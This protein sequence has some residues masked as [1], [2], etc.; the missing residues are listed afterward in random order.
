MGT[1]FSNKKL[2]LLIF[3]LFLGIFAVLTFKIFSG[4]SRLYSCQDVLDKKDGIYTIYP[5]GK[6]PVQARCRFEKG[7]AWTLIDISLDKNWISYF[8][9]PKFDV[10]QKGYLL[11]SSCYSY[12]DWFRVSS[13]K[14]NFATSPDC[15]NIVEE[16]KVYRATGNFYGCLW[17]S[18]NDPKNSYY[19]GPYDF[20]RTASSTNKY[21]DESGK[22]WSC[23]NDW[24]NTAPSIGADGK[25]CVAYTN[26]SFP[27]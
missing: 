14:M 2:F 24:W 19:N 26:F 16:N 1:D 18:G 27:D 3:L 10:E 4:K 22:C 8:D 20:Y 7:A 6:N 12:Y 25:H 21:I 17:F 5:D 11:H 9:Q 15:K 13:P 23:Q